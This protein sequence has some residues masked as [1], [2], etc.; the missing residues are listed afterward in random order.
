M[1]TLSAVDVDPGEIIQD[2]VKPSS[3]SSPNIPLNAGVAVVMGLAVG[4]GL[5]FLRDR[6]DDRL[7]GRTDL[8]ER[9]GAP[10]LA[11]I[12]KVETWRERREPKLVTLSEP[13][14]AAAEAYRTLR[15]S[16]MFAAS[17]EGLKTIMVTSPGPGEGK[18]TT[19]ANLAVVLA[20]ADKRVILVSADHRKQS[21]HRPFGLTSM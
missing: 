9:T 18:P 13:K 16:V 15:T 1:G 5:A 20:Q 3:P 10:V 7:R 6:L 8:E 14:S 12:P 2:A 11:V 17:Q 21:P 19:A 4:I